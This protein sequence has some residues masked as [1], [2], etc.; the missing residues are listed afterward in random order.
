M[1]A[2]QLWDAVEFGDVEF[3]DDRRALEVLCVAVPTEIGASLANK[4]TSK[5]AWDSIGTAC[6]GDHRIRHAMLQWL[7]QEWEGLAFN[8]GEQ[9]EDFAFRLSSLKDQMAH[10]G[11]T[12][13][14]DARTVEKLLRCIPK[15]YSQ[16]VLAIETLLDFEALSIEEVTGR[17]KAVQD[18][19]EAPHTK[20]STVGGKLLYTAEQWLAF[21]KKKDE[22]S[23]SCPPREHCWR[24]R[25]GKKKEDKGPRGNGGADGGTADER[26]ATQDDTCLNCGK[27]GHW[28]KDCRLPPRRGEQAHVAQAEE[29]DHAL[30]LVHEC[31]EL[32]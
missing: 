9:V 13:I 31:I 11:D 21:E 27:T 2:R 17:L 1:Q 24:P 16:I 29:E 10:N 5:K 30:F 15:K 3:H 6:R 14:T 28:A 23:G 25:G 18:R 12:D 22:A 19:E 8:L 7:R 32:R 20:S 26:M 4:A